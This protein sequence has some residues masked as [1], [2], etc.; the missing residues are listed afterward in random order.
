LLH[1]IRRMLEASGGGLQSHAQAN[2][3]V[4]LKHYLV[5]MLL[6]HRVSWLR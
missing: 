3:D 5:Q 1:T 4:L 6:L 2:Y